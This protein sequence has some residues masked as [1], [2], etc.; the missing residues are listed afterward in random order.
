MRYIIIGINWSINLLL[1]LYF[2]RSGNF[3]NADWKQ[4]LPLMAFVI[5]ANLINFA[6]YRR[7][8]PDFTFFEF[9]ISVITIFL[10]WIVLF[11]VYVLLVFVT[12]FSSSDGS[13]FQN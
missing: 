8:K 13:L 5:T 9:L 10:V 6:L 4:V 12:F 1:L 11:F 3:H 2:Y 7:L